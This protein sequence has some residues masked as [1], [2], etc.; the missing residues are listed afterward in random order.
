MSNNTNIKIVPALGKDFNKADIISLYD[1]NENV[2]ARFKLHNTGYISNISYNEQKDLITLISN[3]VD[4]SKVVFANI[5][6]IDENIIKYAFIN[7]NR[8]AFTKASLNR[9]NIEINP[10]DLELIDVTDLDVLKQFG[11]V[12]IMLDEFKKERGFRITL[13]CINDNIIGYVAY[14][15]IIKQIHR[16]EIKEEYRGN[17]LGRILL[18]NIL[19]D[20]IWI[21]ISNHIYSGFFINLGAFRKANNVYLISGCEELEEFTK[22]MKTF[23]EANMFNLTVLLTEV[24]G[25]YNKIPLEYHNRLTSIKTTEDIENFVLNLNK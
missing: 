17:G 18:E 3:I 12:N 23:K 14:N 13:L 21:A 11:I 2:L 7:N 15:D 5:N 4:A 1:E 16:I 25:D 10:K 6:E 19:D 20:S 22:N 8:V 24:F 9:E